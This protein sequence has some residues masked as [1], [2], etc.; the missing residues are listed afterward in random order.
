MATLRSR[1]GYYIFVLWFLSI[2]FPRLFAAVA[3]WMSTDTVW[4]FGLSANL[5]C[6][7]KRA[8]RGSLN[9]QDAANRQ[10]FATY[11][12]HRTTLSGYIFATKTRINNRKKLLNSN[13]SL[14]C[15]YN[16]VNFGPPADEIVSLVWGTT[17]HYT[18][19]Y[20]IC[21]LVYVMEDVFLF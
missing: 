8:A 12:H 11:G 14:T 20:D 1:W 15:P 6:R 13:I 4:R 9:I 21:R 2:F 10:K 3:D 18:A 17:R 5:G 16:M 7:L 19:L